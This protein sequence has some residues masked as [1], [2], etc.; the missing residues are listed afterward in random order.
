MSTQTFF[1]VTMRRV[2]FFGLGVVKKMHVKTLIAKR[3]MIIFLLKDCALLQ[4]FHL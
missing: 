3:F 4:Q 2:I 1:I